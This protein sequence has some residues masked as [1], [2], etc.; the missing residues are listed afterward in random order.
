MESDEMDQALSAVIAARS[1][2][3]ISNLALFAEGL[4]IAELFILG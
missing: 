4:R 1:L 2:R 3:Q